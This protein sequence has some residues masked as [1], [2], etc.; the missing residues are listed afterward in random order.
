MSLLV[1]NRDVWEELGVAPLLLC[2]KKEPGEVDWASYQDVSWT[3]LCGRFPCISH[4]RKQQ[5]E[6]VGRG[7]DFPNN[8]GTPVELPE[9]SGGHGWAK[10]I[11]S[12]L[13][14]LKLK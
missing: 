6:N 13:L 10:D 12:S 5:S 11:C 1:T 9:T 8:L 7:L 4:W 3:P 2:I 14:I